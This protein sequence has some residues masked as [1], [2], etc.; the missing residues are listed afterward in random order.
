MSCKSIGYTRTPTHRHTHTH[1]REVNTH[2]EGTPHTHIKGIHTHTHTHTHTEHAL[3]ED[4]VDV[5]P[6]RLRPAVSPPAAERHQLVRRVRVVLRRHARMRRESH[7]FGLQELW[8]LEA[9][10]AN[11]LKEDFRRQSFIYSPDNASI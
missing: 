8:T 2:T 7:V 3:S 9:D 6:A 5:A 10:A 11:K 4:V 1:T